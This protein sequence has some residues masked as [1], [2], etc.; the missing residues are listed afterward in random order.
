MTAPP[1]KTRRGLLISVDGPGAVGKSTMVAALTTEL[2]AR[3]EA[4][5]S[6]REPTDTPLGNL[7]R[8]G[9]EEYRGMPMACLIAADRYQHLTT[10]IAPALLRGEIVLCDRY[11]ASSLVLQ[12]MDGL[13][14]H[15]IWDLNRHARL[16][17]LAL[18]L[19]ADPDTIAARLAC[20]G[21]HSRYE[22]IPHSSHIEH[23]LY[24]DA[25]TFLRGIGVRVRELDA[26]TADPGTL[27]RTAA[28]EITAL[29]TRDRP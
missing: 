13:D 21:A 1:A 17:H 20:R 9:T 29:R 24:A 8:H 18:L 11:I 2:R 26:T 6:T 15:V 16:P 3:R 28:A 14:P 25:A 5:W 4:V 27:A 23:T 12:R 22:R 19:I 10:E 7:A